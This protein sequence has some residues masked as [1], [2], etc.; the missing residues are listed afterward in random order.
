MATVVPDF[1]FDRHGKHRR[2]PVFARAL[3]DEGIAAYGFDAEGSGLA[4]ASAEWSPKPWEAMTSQVCRARAVVAGQH[5]QDT[6]H[7]LIGVGIGGVATVLSAVHTPPTAMVLIGSDLVQRV[8]FVVTGLA[9]VRGGEQLLPSRVFRDRE[10]LAPRD[11]LAE[12]SIPVLCVHG[13]RDPRF[14]LADNDLSAYGA[15]VISVSDV[16]DPLQSHS[17]TAL[18][19]RT[20]RKWMAETGVIPSDS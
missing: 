7:V 15:Q 4:G 8:R 1:T 20:V 5:R 16:A 19:A 6:R 18:T 12:L 10:R 13:G 17:S 3:R 9:G 11:R 14:R 2:G